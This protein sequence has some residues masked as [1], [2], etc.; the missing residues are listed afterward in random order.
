MAQYFTE[1]NCTACGARS[2]GFRDN[3]GESSDC[4]R[5]GASV[6]ANGPEFSDAEQSRMCEALGIPFQ[7]SDSVFAERE[8]REQFGRDI[9]GANSPDDC[10]PVTGRT[11]ESL[12][13]ERFEDSKEANHIDGFDRDDL[14]ESPDY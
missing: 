6:E 8:A 9:L 10:E 1:W 14:G 3:E 5:C 13:R 2:E 11:W 12:T 4:W 7:D